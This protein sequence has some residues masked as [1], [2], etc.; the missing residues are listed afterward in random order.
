MKVLVTG[1]LGFI[2]SN[3]IRYLLSNYSD[4]EVINLDAMKYGSNPANLKDLEDDERYTFIKGD[5][6]DY[7]LMAELVK[8]VNTKLTS[9]LKHMS[10]EVYPI[11]ILF[12]KVMSLVCLRFW[13]L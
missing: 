9:Q 7:E 8:D 1:G 5:I 12:C 2:G 10:I 4:V 13:R 11:Y 3:F 6:S